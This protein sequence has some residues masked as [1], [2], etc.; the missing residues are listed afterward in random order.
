[1]SQ[2]WFESPS[3]NFGSVTVMVGWD[4][5]LQWF[6]MY[7][8]WGMDDDDPLY[9]NLNELFPD[10]LDLAYFQRVLDRFGITGVSLK[11]NTTGLYESLMNDREND[12]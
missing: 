9:S 5:P 12:L 8:G 10:I 11:E 7:I 3:R 6:H 4:E 2:Y 1:M